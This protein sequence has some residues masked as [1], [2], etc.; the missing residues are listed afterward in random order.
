MINLYDKEQNQIIPISSQKELEKIYEHKTGEE[1]II[2]RLL[3]LPFSL[4]VDYPVTYSNYGF[5][6]GI[7]PQTIKGTSTDSSTIS[8]STL[9]SE[10]TKEYSTTNIQGENVDEADITKTDGNYI[11]SLS[12]NDVVITDVRKAEEMKIVAR[13]SESD[14]NTMPVS[15]THLTLPT[16]A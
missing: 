11:Y 16:K 3:K 14:S 2:N 1:S 6:V 10:S 13:I 15:Y 7:S 5:D 4:L 12:E 9:K 8:N